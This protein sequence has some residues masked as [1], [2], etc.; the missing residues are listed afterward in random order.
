MTW[1][2]LNQGTATVTGPW[3]DGVYLSGDDQF[4]NAKLLGAFVHQGGL[5]SGARYSQQQTLTLPVDLAAGTY[6]IF[7]QTDTQNQV[8]EPGA[9]GNNVFLSTTPTGGEPGAGAGPCGQTGDPP[10]SGHRRHWAGP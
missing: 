6:R 9:K 1:Q 8:Q 3:S 5:D 7:V 2:V 4:A 10:Y